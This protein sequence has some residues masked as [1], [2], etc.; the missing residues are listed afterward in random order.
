MLNLVLYGIIGIGAGLFLDDLL[1]KE[2]NTE[3]EP[4]RENG[5]S[6][7]GGGVSDNA[8]PGKKRGRKRVLKD[9]DKRE[10]DDG[11]GESGN[12]DVD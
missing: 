1:K 6:S 11:D 5:A 12:D 10:P 8:R 2:G 9:D 3:D 7:S 4:V